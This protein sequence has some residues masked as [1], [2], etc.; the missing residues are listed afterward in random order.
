MRQFKGKI[1]LHVL[2]LHRWD[3]S[4]SEA[5]QIQQVIRSRISGTSE[6]GLVR[7]VAGVD[8]GFQSGAA[9]AAVV[10][11]S[12][13]DLVQ[14]ETRLARRPVEF[15]YVPGLLS[16][17]EA[18]AV[19]DAIQ[20]IENDP[21]LIFVD[22]QGIAHPRRV[23]IASHVGVLVDRA[24]IG[25]AKS[26]LCGKHGVVGDAVGAYAYIVDRGEIIGA[27]LRT[28]EGVKPVYVSIGHKIDLETA[29]QFV[30][31]CCR[32]YRLPEPTRLAHLAAARS[33]K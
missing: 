4:P 28:K 23:G 19:L 1:T 13:P 21:D 15:P 10:V 27:A 7:R 32:G 6:L 26:L 25:C 16:F 9:V 22:G 11:L 18:P 30:L 17:R 5:V 14:I 3:V 24:T 12:Y 29:I 2:Q 33:P 20:G 31:S 8:V